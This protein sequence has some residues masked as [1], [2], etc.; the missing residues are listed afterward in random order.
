VCPDD[1]NPDETEMGDE[2]AD[3]RER[4]QHRPLVGGNPL[5]PGHSA[6]GFAVEDRAS[7][8]ATAATTTIGAVLFGQTTTVP[9]TTVVRVI[10]DQLPSDH[11]FEILLAVL[12]GL[13]TLA[14]VL[15]AA[16]LAVRHER[17]RTGLERSQVAADQLARAMDPALRT[18]AAFDWQL[19]ASTIH[20]LGDPTLLKPLHEWTM[21]NLGVEAR[22]VALLVDGKLRSA[23]MDFFWSVNGYTFTNASPRAAPRLRYEARLLRAFGAQLRDAL[24]SHA[25]GDRYEVPA[26]V[27]E[28]LHESWGRDDAVDPTLIEAV[29]APP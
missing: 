15:L 29:P 4:A 10:V 25:R 23:Y 7:A 14:G 16:W 12:S 6:L 8:I 13:I 3:I 22:D 19:I 21:A 11:G 9:P 5:A 17:R 27:T 28:A 18:F 24:F 26:G 20:G 1:E 2:A